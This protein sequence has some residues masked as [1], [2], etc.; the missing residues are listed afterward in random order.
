MDKAA[1]IM[2]ESADIVAATAAKIFADLA[3]PQVINSS[4]DDSWKPR[5]WQALAQTGLTLAW[6]P[7]K[8]GGG[9]GSRRRF[10]DHQ[11]RGAIR[12]PRSDCRDAIRGLAPLPGRDLVACGRDGGRT[13]ASG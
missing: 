7:E 4:T 5:L 6:V 2:S 10:C 1:R 8:Q 12:R 3:D 13:Y 11:C 9:G